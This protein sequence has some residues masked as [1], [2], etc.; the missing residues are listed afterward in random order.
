MCYFMTINYTLKRSARARSM[1][2][3]VY[4][5]GD[6]RVT[7]PRMVPGF[8]V[9]RFVSNKES[10]ITRKVA[11]FKARPIIPRPTLWGTGKRREYLMYKKSA[12]ALVVGKVNFF[13]GKYGFS[14]GK[15]NIRNQKTRWGSCSRKG[16]LSFSYRIVFLPT[17]LQD[18]LVIHELCHLKEFNHSRSFWNLVGKEI[19]GYKELRKKLKGIDR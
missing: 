4:Q 19:V 14:Y 15:I 1:R 13:A 7:A 12:H 17:E 6:V 2:I 16:N 3:T 9:K 18:Y 11:E 10:W 5:T 8:L